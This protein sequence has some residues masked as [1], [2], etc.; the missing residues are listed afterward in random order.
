M[1]NNVQ[2]CTI[3]SIAPSTTGFGYAFIRKPASFIKW[4]NKWISGSD[5]NRKT[6]IVAG[7][8]IKRFVPS[9]IVLPDALE[10]GSRR[11]KRIQR[12]VQQ[13]TSLAVEN[14]IVIK[15][16]TQKE[17]R[18]CF[19]E[20]KTGTKYARAK[21]LAQR[22]P[23]ELAHLL[24]PKRQPWMHEDPNLGTFDAVAFVLT[25]FNLEKYRGRNVLH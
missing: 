11:A 23:Q 22:F 15:L 12:L 9:T 7:K 8:M 21:I 5:K 2:E 4:G 24:P 13:I 16:I 18:D 6:L 1:N 19:F 25:Y 3:L 17:L 10:K 20:G 14:G